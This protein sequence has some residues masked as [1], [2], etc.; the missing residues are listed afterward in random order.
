MNSIKIDKIIVQTELAELLQVAILESMLLS[1]EKDC[2][3]EIIHTA[4]RR[5]V[6][7]SYVMEVLKKIIENPCPKEYH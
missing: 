5:L 3:V 4:G 6:E 1:Y 7:K 2:D